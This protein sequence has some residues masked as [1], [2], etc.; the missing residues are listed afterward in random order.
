M[1]SSR[2]AYRP[3]IAVAIALVVLAA[4]AAVALAS[5]PS[6][7]TPKVLARGTYDAFKVRS[8]PNSPV[9][10]KAKTKGRTDIV[11]RQHDYAVGS[12]TGWHSHPGPVFITVTLGE[13]TFYERDDPTC[14]PHVVSAGHGYVD[15]GQGHIGRARRLARDDDARTRRAAVLAI[16]A[17]LTS[18]KACLDAADQLVSASEAEA[19]ALKAELDAGETEALQI[20]LGAGGTGKGSAGAARGSAGALKDLERRQKSR[21]T[22]AQRDA[23]D[24]ALVDLAAFYR[25]VLM[26]H[27]GAD[28]GAAHPDLDDDVRAVALRVPP[29]GVL[30][31]LDAVLACRTALDLNVKPRIAVEAMTAALRLR[32]GGAI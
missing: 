18:M 15:T 3:A 12:S 8:S 30:K 31:R 20:A 17:S 16:P 11:V 19:N 5:P 1:K 13:V 22:R 4:V 14:A 28:V 23:L 29:A 10:F 27:A 7:V 32:I 6:G 26:V 24:R 21:A 9:D 25:D 2:F